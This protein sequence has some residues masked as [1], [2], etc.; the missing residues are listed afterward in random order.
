[1]TYT[2][3]VQSLGNINSSCS[4]SST[5]QSATFT[6][7]PAERLTHSGTITNTLFTGATVSTTTNGQ[8]SQAVCEGG[9]IQGIRIEVGG[10]ATGA[11]H[12][13]LVGQNGLPVGVV[14]TPFKE[15]QVKT[16]SISGTLTVSETLTIKINGVSYQYTIQ[17]GDAASNVAIGLRNVINNAIGI[18]LSPVTAAASGSII[19][20]SADQSGKSF[21]YTTST[22]TNTLELDGDV[23]GD[24]ENL[25]YVTITGSPSEVVSSTKTYSVDI[26]SVGTSCTPVKQ[27]V[28]ISLLPN[29]KISFTSAAGT[30]NQE[31]CD[32]EPIPFPIT[33]QLSNGA[34][35]IIL[36][37]ADFGQQDRVNIS[38]V[39]AAND[40]VTVTIDET[41]YQYTVPVGATGIDNIITNLVTNMSG[42]SVINAIPD[43]ANDAIYLKSSI[44]GAAYSLELKTTTGTVT[45]TDITPSS[46]RIFPNGISVTENAVAQQQVDIVSVAGTFVTGED[47]F[48]YVTGGAPLTTNTYSHTTVGGGLSAT[49]VR[50][51]LI[52]KINAT[53]GRRVQALAGPGGGDITLTANTSGAPFGL[54]QFTNSVTPTITSVNSVGSHRVTISGTPNVGVTF[55]STYFYR[56]R[57]ANNLLGCGEDFIQGSIKVNPKEGINYDSSDSNFPGSD[58]AQQICVGEQIE[59]IKFNLTGTALT[60]SIPALAGT[61]GLPPGVLLNPVSVRQVNI[62][63]V[64]ASSAIGAQFWIKIDGVTYSYTTSTTG[65]TALTVAQQLVSGINIASGVRQSAPTAS[66][67]GTTSIQ[68]RA[69]VQGTLFDLSFNNSI[70]GGGALSL[71]S[72]GN[73]DNENYMTVTGTPNPATPITTTVAYTFTLT[74]SGTAGCL[75]GDA[76]NTA[77]GTITLT[78]ESTLVLSSALATLNQEV[79]ANNAILLISFI[80][81]EEE[82]QV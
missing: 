21:S 27:T 72:S 40:K 10:S 80:R 18:R 44:D 75:P 22:T 65:D 48:I 68:I 56:I 31:V 41:D 42:S 39:F 1:M 55:P 51:A 17:T 20:L 74:T 12:P 9:D 23:A 13:S 33:Y 66:I 37:S 45:S 6:V 78:P 35:E 63:D 71:A 46:S 5:T 61:V 19:T 7:I 38:G 26:T 43:L 67:T 58:N 64:T 32:G 70:A 36:E 76:S 69:N 30:D 34:T 77:N 4:V 52:A 81:S 25:N 11:T 24:V 14:M 82:R 79:C 73:I 49:N 59:G 3:I 8:L 62:I 28:S 54:S 2:Y 50:D 47:V 15:A 57:T 60:A 29:S 16:T 53:P